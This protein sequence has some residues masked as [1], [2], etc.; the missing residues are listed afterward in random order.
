MIQEELKE[1]LKIELYNNFDNYSFYLGVKL[2]I[3]EEEIDSSVSYHT[4]L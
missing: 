2:K 4:K 3:D 1:F